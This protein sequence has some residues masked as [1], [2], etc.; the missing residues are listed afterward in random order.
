M[1][2]WKIHNSKL[3]KGQLDEIRLIRWDHPHT[4]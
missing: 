4:Q 3:T 1:D 2:N